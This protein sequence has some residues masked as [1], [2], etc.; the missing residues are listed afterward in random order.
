MLPDLNTELQALRKQNLYRSVRRV[1]TSQEPRIRIKGRELILFCSNNYLGLANHPVL[2]DA[3][4]E[5]LNTY[6]SST[7]ASALISG[8]M[9]PHADLESSMAQFLDTEAAIAFPTGYTANLGVIPALINRDDIIYSDQLN[10]RSIID[11]CRLSR[12]Q[13]AIY[14]HCDIAHLETQLRT[15]SGHRRRL[16]VTDGVFSMDGDIAPLPELVSL[17]E[18]HN[19]ILMV[20]DAHATGVLGPGGRGTFEHYGLS[21][22]TIDILMTS[23]SKALGASGGF[24]CG[25]RDLI[26]LIR[27]R[28]AAY[29]YTTAMPPDACASTTAALDLIQR[30]TSLRQRL[31]HNTTTISQ[32]LQT[33]GYDLAQSQTHI[34][35][36]LVGDAQ[37]TVEISEHLYNRGIYLYGIRPP[38]VP[39]GQSRLRLSV[40]ATHTDDDIAQ[41]LDAMTEV[42]HS[43][44][45][46]HHVQPPRPHPNRTR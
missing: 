22:E 39:E 37:K 12:A 24:I 23:G 3:A 11:G 32:H 9:P 46:D 5:A 42:R 45:G 20:D 21:P 43:F 26:D 31:W 38:T 27:N 19:A 6:G 16:I 18:Q 7:V 30:E 35:P 33:L 10:H 17:A 36:V 34:I 14:N 8:Y 29:I 25:S 44:F 41:V 15:S 1:E 2:K 4:I 40:M 13:I 28:S